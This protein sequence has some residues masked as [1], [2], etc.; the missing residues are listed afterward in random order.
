MH[1]LIHFFKTT[2]KQFLYFFSTFIKIIIFTLFL[3]LYFSPSY[4]YFCKNKVK[5]VKAPSK[6]K[7]KAPAP[8]PLGM[9]PPAPPTGAPGSS[10]LPALTPGPAQIFFHSTRPT[11]LQ[12]QI[13]ARPHLDKL[14]LSFFFSTD[15]CHF[16]CPFFLF[17]LIGGFVG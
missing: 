8:S 4:F 14:R 9:S 12:A 17:V 7:V 10:L 16:L 13:T 2:S 1:L 11:H 15:L 5:K 3:L 6:K